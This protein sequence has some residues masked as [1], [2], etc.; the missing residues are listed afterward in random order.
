MAEIIKGSRVSG[1]VFELNMTTKRHERF[2]FTGVVEDLRPTTWSCDP[3]RKT[4]VLRY[5][6]IDQHRKRFLGDSDM[7]LH[8]EL[9]HPPLTLVDTT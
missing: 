2:N 6:R 7:V 1:Y 8:S 5:I 3:E 9:H 4:D